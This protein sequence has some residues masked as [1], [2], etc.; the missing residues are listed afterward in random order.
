ML[1]GTNKRADVKTFSG[2]KEFAL[3]FA[4]FV[5]P[6][7][8]TT[9]ARYDERDRAATE[10]SAILAAE[11]EPVRARAD[12]LIAAWEKDRTAKSSEPRNG[13]T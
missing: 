4:A 1:R 7:M 11:V 13:P 5:I 3:A 6:G 10:R 2:P 9:L 12:A 8:R